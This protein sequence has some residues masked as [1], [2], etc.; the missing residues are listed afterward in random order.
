MRAKVIA[1]LR[2]ATA[3]LRW[4]LSA[5]HLPAPSADA[6]GASSRRRGFAAWLFAG[7]EI[8]DTSCGPAAA[9]HRRSWLRWVLSPGQLPAASDKPNT[10][11]VRPTSFWGWLL[12]GEE[13]RECNLREKLLAPRVGFLRW[14][15]STTPYPESRPTPRQRGTFLDW[16]A[17]AD[18]CPQLSA[19]V[20]RGHAGFLRWLLLSDV[21]PQS[22]EPPRRHSEGFWRL[23]LSPGSCPRVEEPP[24]RLR[25]KLGH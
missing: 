5:E 18:S 21:C 8:A 11:A 12:G 20:T 1:I 7:D 22:E 10:P 17:A 2:G 24:R 4:L 16:I 6:L 23:V 19:P 13:L 3:F 14:L 9:R 15:F 25:K